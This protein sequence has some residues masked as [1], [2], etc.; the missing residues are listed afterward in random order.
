MAQ[1]SKEFRKLRKHE[2]D[3][4]INQFPLHHDKFV[5]AQS[6]M[7]NYFHRVAKFKWAE[8]IQKELWSYVQNDFNFE[9]GVELEEEN[10]DP[11]LLRLF[12]QLKLYMQTVMFE[13]ME[14]GLR[15]YLNFILGFILR[16]TELE[17]KKDNA[18]NNRLIEELKYDKY[19]RLGYEPAKQFYQPKEIINDIDL[20]PKRTKPMILIDTAI[21]DMEVINKNT[22]KQVVVT[23]PELSKVSEDLSAIIDTMHTAIEEVDRVDA[24]IFPLLELEEPFLRVPVVRKDSDSGD[25]LDDGNEDEGDEKLCRYVE[26]I[27]KLITSSLK[28]TRQKVEYVKGYMTI[29]EKRT[30]NIIT[31]LKIKSFNLA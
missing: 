16:D 21:E 2:I 27:D 5:A 12:Y 30:D 14:S 7:A 3:R 9:M 28:S 13:H 8:T 22:K 18:P 19:I 23:K 1:N 15:D 4:M 11:V 26:M 10:I 20:I 29:F 6:I 31:E 25:A 24:L 17:E